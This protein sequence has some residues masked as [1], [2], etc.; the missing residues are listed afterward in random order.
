MY[1]DLEF[2]WSPEL[3]KWIL[4]VRDSAQVAIATPWLTDF[5]IQF[6][7]FKKR[8]YWYEARLFP[9]LHVSIVEKL[10]RRAMRQVPRRRWGYF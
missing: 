8:G 2:F 1:H 10:E 4:R 9:P 3:H 6:H 7:P 5:G